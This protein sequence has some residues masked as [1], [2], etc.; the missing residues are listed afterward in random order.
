MIFR[1][2]LGDHISSSNKNLEEYQ[3]KVFIN[4]QFNKFSAIGKFRKDDLF[5]I[6]NF[7][8]DYEVLIRKSIKELLIKYKYIRI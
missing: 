7:K 2:K 6:D 8:K 3:D 1:V 4:H 5:S